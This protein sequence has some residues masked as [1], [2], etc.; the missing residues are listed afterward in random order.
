MYDCLFKVRCTSSISV[1]ILYSGVYKFKEINGAGHEIIKKAAVN[2][3]MIVSPYPRV[4]HNP[5]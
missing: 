4:R 2:T 3:V 1:Y 5:A